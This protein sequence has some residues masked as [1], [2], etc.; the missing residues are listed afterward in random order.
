MCPTRAR[1][2]FL[3]GWLSEADFVQTPVA[4]ADGRRPHHRVLRFSG[5]GRRTQE[6]E[7]GVLG[8]GILRGGG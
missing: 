1:V 8:V 7:T 3:D 4:M 5:S 6:S 2:V